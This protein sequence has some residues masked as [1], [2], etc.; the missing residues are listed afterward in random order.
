MNFDLISNGKM[1][2]NGPGNGQNGGKIYENWDF[3][4][5]FS[6]TLVEKL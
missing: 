6:N 1:A 4:L 5:F 3:Q 2:E